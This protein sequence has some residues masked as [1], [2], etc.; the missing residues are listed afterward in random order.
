MAATKIMIIRHAERPADD[1][2]ANG[3]TQDG[4]KDPEELIVRGWQR[5][6]A[7]VRFFAPVGGQFADPH[8][9]TPDIIFASKVAHHS[10]SLRSQH[11]VK[12]LADFLHKSLVLKHAK[13][14]EDALVA[15]AIAAN[16]TVLI[17]WEHEAIPEIGNLITGNKT[18]CPQKWH[19]SRFDLVWVL[20]RPGPS[21]GWSFAQVP[22]LLLPGDSTEASTKG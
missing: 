14:E 19:G 8:L 6:G 17:A 18:I 21:G 22:Q 13:G 1:G 3:V 9:G 20:D 10:P 2:S 11:T 7:L 12:S 16:G 15:D 4:T 5:A